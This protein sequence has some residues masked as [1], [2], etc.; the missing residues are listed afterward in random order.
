LLAGIS[1]FAGK[2]GAA[3]WLPGRKHKRKLGRLG[4]ACTKI[5]CGGG[6]FA[7][8]GG[9]LLSDAA[10]PAS[11]IVPLS[12]KE[13]PELLPEPPPELPP[14]ELPPLPDDELGPSKPALELPEPHAGAAKAA[15]TI[16]RPRQTDGRSKFLSIGL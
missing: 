1:L 11:L 8:G 14:L 3:D 10:S 16:P 15:A 7:S 9:G 6:I 5:I 4:D 13:P 2:G 12:P